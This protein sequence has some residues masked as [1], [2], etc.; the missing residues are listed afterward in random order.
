MLSVELVLQ[1]IQVDPG[2][3]KS[4]ALSKKMQIAAGMTST[5]H[6][7]EISDVWARVMKTF[8]I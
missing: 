4:L 2:S 3:K 6:A 5:Y 7:G 1:R 8:D